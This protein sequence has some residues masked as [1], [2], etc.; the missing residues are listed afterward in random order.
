MKQTELFNRLNYGV[1]VV[2]TALI[3]AIIALNGSLFYRM[4]NEQ[5]EIIGREQLETV[6]GRLQGVLKEAEVYLWQAESE[7]ESLLQQGASE[8]EILYIAPKEKMKD[9]NLLFLTKDGMI[10]QVPAEEFETNNRQVVSTKLTDDDRV[11]EMLPVREIGQNT[12]CIWTKDGYFLR[13]ALDDVPILKKASKGVHGIKLH[14]NDEAAGVK[15]IDSD[16]VVRFGKKEIR[17]NTLKTALRGG[18]GT[19]QKNT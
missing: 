12:L 14:K 17:L 16:S 2:V 6:S 5:A 7:L 10:K 4:T 8:E 3:L 9:L 1:L 18:T 13:F 15:I 11:V 19:K